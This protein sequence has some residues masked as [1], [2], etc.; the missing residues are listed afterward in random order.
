MKANAKPVRF[1]NGELS[2]DVKSSSMLY[3]LRSFTG[4]GIRNAANEKLGQEAIRK[5]AFRLRN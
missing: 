4:E 1:R 5:V 3:E 2:V